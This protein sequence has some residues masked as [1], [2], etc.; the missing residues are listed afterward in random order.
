M[1]LLIDDD[2]L[3]CENNRPR[4]PLHGPT[5]QHPNIAVAVRYITM[6]SSDLSSPARLSSCAHA[7]FE[8]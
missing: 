2:V 1:T 7:F 4:S 5:E 3:S 8:C 6:T